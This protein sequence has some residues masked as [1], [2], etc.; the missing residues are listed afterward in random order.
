MPV[1]EWWWLGI[2]IAVI[3]AIGVAGA[4]CSP[5]C[6][7]RARPAATASIGTATLLSPVRWP[8][9]TVAMSHIGLYSF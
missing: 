7:M 3:I 1:S 8:P 6:P 5:T 9:I 2:V 4:A